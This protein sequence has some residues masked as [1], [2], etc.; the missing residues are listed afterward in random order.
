MNELSYTFICRVGGCIT[1]CLFN[2]EFLNHGRP[3]V[4]HLYFTVS[5]YSCDVSLLK[6]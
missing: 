3:T 4:V 6:F 1:F 5:W 2:N